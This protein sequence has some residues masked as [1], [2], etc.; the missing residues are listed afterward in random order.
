MRRTMKT[1]ML[2][3]AVLVAPLALVIGLSESNAGA[4]VAPYVQTA[5]STN[6]YYDW[7]YLKKDVSTSDIYFFTSN[8]N[9]PG[10][11]PTYN[12]HATGVYYTGSTK[13]WSIFNQD[14]SAIPVGASF[15]VVG[16]KAA[17]NI[18]VHTATSGT[19]AG[20]WTNLSNGYTNNNPNALVWVTP[21]WN[22]GV[23]ENH[24]I[25][26]WYTGSNWAIFNQDGTAIPTNACFDV[27]IADGP[28][29]PEAYVATANSGNIAGDTMFLDNPLLNGV[30]GKELMVTPNW[31]P[32]GGPNVYDN[33]PI[34]VWYDTS[35]KRYGVFN[36]DGAAMPN[37]A[38]FNIWVMK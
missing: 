11:T 5:T 29:W 14:T 20:D 22:T 16:L 15:N 36:Q 13:G 8:W 26:V 10:K 4:Q 2:R 7:T 3:S 34:G 21:N 38:S 1:A 25:G 31:S 33:H 19:L 37:G 12:N 23:Y 35:N 28:F 27:I 9:P 17:S 18:Y 30:T 6:V 24:N 32:P